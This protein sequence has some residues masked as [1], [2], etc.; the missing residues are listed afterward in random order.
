MYVSLHQ[1]FAEIYNNLQM[2]LDA[3]CLYRQSDT[4]LLPITIIVSY[5]VILC[6]PSAVLV[7]SYVILVA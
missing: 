1:L 3:V 4:L 5:C 2:L 6:N 7:A